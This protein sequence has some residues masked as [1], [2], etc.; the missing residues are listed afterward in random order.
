M[1]ASWR[2]TK[3]RLLKKDTMSSAKR[4]DR[5]IGVLDPKHMMGIILFL[6]ENGPSRKVDIYENVSRNANMPDKLEVL[7]D[8]GIIEATT[9]INGVTLTLTD[10]GTAVA[11][12]LLSIES[13]L[14]VG[15]EVR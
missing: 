15:A 7:M 2:C 9:S 10:S 3:H 5:P 14:K 11:N 12:M 8:S 6:H 13:V 4:I 1:N